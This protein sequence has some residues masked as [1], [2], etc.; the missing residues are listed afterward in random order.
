MERKLHRTVALGAAALAFAV[1]SPTAEAWA[2]TIFV[3]NASFET[4]GPGG[5]PFDGCGTG[6]SYSSGAIPGWTESGD[7]GQ[8][9]PGAVPNA[10]YNSIPDGITVAYANLGSISQI[11]GATA[12]AGVTYTLQVDVGF[13]KDI[14]ADGFVDLAVGGHTIAATGTFLN[15]SGDWFTYTASYKATAL[16]IGAPI[17]ITLGNTDSEAQGAW[18]NVRLSS[19]AVVPLPAALPLFAGGLGAVGAITRWRRRRNA[20][21]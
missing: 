18:D 14:D 8:F 16:D 21:A 5:L 1:A 20:A 11:V 4:I 9:Q 2:A 17:T 6:C 13:R 19:N 3:D 12:Q 7:A 10:Y 15:E